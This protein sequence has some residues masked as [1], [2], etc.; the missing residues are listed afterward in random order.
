MKEKEDLSEEVI[1]ENI[2]KI[3]KDYGK[4]H[5]IIK[6]IPGGINMIRDLSI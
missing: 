6:A 3:I 5:N 1:L 4:Y 2:T